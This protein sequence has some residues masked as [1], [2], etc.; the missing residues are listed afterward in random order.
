MTRAQGLTHLQNEFSAL[1]AEAKQDTTD[2]A[3]G[4]GPALD[5][6]FLALGTTGT[7]PD[8]D[9]G[10]FMALAEYHALHRLWRTL[11]TRADVQARNVMGP[12]AQVFQ[13]VKDL[14]AEASERCAELGYP[15][16]GTAAWS[17]GQI[18]LDYLE[19]EPS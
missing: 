18:N 17:Y 6:A 19:P 1:A 10:A 11:A 2:S 16:H 7:A 13:H 3:A 14:M 9:T 12:R 15:V 8:A 4:F 5:R